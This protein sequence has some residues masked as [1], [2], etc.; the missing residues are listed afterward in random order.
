[1]YVLIPK[2]K[3]HYPWNFAKL[4]MRKYAF[5]LFLQNSLCAFEKGIGKGLM[6]RCLV[7]EA[8]A[9]AGGAAFSISSGMNAYALSEWMVWTGHRI[10]SQYVKKQKEELYTFIFSF[11]NGYF[12]M[13]YQWVIVFWL[14]SQCIVEMIWTGKWIDLFLPSIFLCICRFPRF[15]FLPF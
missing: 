1:M 14:I 5:L 13:N 8:S 15:L 2:P 4:F 10:T 7:H 3:C 12:S 11:F 9:R 6:S